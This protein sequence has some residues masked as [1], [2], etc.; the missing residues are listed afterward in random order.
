[1]RRAKTI[2][3]LV[4]VAASAAILAGGPASATGSTGLVSVGSGSFPRAGAASEEQVRY[5]PRRRLPIRMKCPKGSG[6]AGRY[7]CLNYFGTCTVDCKLFARTTLVLP[8]PN[9]GPENAS[10]S[11]DA[12]QVFVAYIRLTRAGLA[13][14]KQHRRKARLRTR[15][16]AIDLATNEVDIDR[17]TFRFK[18]G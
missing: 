4:V 2:T 12:N 11:F 7:L 3:A 9:I 8:G 16:R 14:L 17:R 1:V 15:I 6:A 10:A 5:L 13:A 18:T